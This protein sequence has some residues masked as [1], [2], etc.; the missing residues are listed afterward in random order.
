MTEVHRNT[1]VRFEY[2]LRI[3]GEKADSS[4]DGE[5]VTVLC[6]HAPSRP[7]GLEAA[8]LGRPPG[9][10]RIVLPPERAAGAHDPLKVTTA[11]R[12]EF[13]ADARVEVGESFYATDEG[14]IPVTVRVVAVEGDRVT[15]DSNPEFAGK[16]LE[17]EGTI[18]SVREATPEEVDHG[19]VHGE[20]GVEH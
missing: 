4:P 13:P 19:H 2:V 8:L 6:G 17:Y 18:H 20:G 12:G 1:V 3:D 5:P 9:Y 7:P 16:P 14:G 15:V 10:F 11:S